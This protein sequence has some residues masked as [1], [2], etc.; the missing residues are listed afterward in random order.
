MPVLLHIGL[1]KAAST[2]L[3]QAVSQRDEV[4]LVS[5]G[6]FGIEQRALATVNGLELPVSP[7]PPALTDKVVVSS[8]ELIGYGPDVPRYQR[9]CAEALAATFPGS[10]VLVITRAPLSF[11]DSFYNQLVKEG[12]SDNPDVFARRWGEFLVEVQYYPRLL[13]LYEGLFGPGSVLCLPMEQ[14]RSSPESAFDAIRRHSGLDLT[15]SR[16]EIIRGNRSLAPKELHAM[17][18]LNKIVS[19][20]ARGPAPT[21]MQ[22]EALD[23]LKRNFISY[24]MADGDAERRFER[25]IRPLHVGPKRPSIL[26]RLTSR[27]RARI[28]EG[29][30][31]LWKL[32]QYASQSTLYSAGLA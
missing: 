4:Q 20:M 14:L 31:P 16:P 25:A 9:L 21:E 17:R 22:R 29:Q 18:V 6:A 30:S 27:Q 7:E 23:R 32:P 1:P 10:K 28:G 3:Q 15:P 11:A 24:Y 26:A 2:F 12:T 13:R 19:I 5:Y 8:E